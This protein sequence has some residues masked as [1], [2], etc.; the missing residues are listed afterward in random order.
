MLVAPL[1]SDA[2]VD[3]N[4]FAIRFDEKTIHVHANAILIVGRMNAGPK[5]ARHDS[6]H[7]AAVE[8]ELTVGNDFKPVIAEFHR[9]SESYFFT[10]FGGAGLGFA[11]GALCGG[12]SGGIIPGGI[13]CCIC[14]G[15]GCGTEKFSAIVM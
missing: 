3:Q 4:S 14:C 9:Q 2:R 13:P 5:V 12:P 8:P 11:P 15:G 1:F 10:P 6:E 7:R